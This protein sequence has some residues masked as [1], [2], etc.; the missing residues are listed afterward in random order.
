[1]KRV[2]QAKVLEGPLVRRSVRIPRRSGEGHFLLLMNI[3]QSPE[4]DKNT[5]MMHMYKMFLDAIPGLSF[6]PTRS[7]RIIDL[8]DIK[9]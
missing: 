3:L 8:A 9:M 7:T 6:R 4:N 1:M 2:V 5:T